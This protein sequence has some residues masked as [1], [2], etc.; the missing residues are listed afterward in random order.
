MAR[1]RS[2]N[3]NEYLTKVA[4]SQLGARGI[5]LDPTCAHTP[6]EN[7]AA[8]RI[9]RTLMNQV[10][11]TLTAARLPFAKYWPWCVLD[12]TGKINN[13]LHATTKQ[14]PVHVWE[15]CRSER[16]PFRPTTGRVDRF[17]VFGELGYVPIMREPKKKSDARATLARYL[18]TLGDTHYQVI[19]VHNGQL[20][21]VWRANFHPYK[22]E[23]DPVSTQRSVRLPIE[24]IQRRVNL[25]H[26]I[27]IT[28]LQAKVIAPQVRLVSN[29]RLP[30][31]VSDPPRTLRAARQS[32][33][34]T[35]WSMA[36][37]KELQTLA[38]FK[39]FRVT[40]RQN[41]PIGATIARPV[42]VFT[43][44]YDNVGA[45]KGHKAR[46]SYPGNI[47]EPGYHFDP[48]QLSVHAADRDSVRLVLA[49]AAELRWDIRHVDLTSAFLH[50]RYKGPRLFLEVPRSFDDVPP[51]RDTVLEVVGNMYG[52]QAAPKRYADGLKEH[53]LTHGYKQSPYDPHVYV[54]ETLHGV[55]IMA[56]TID[57]FAVT[58]SN[59]RLYREMVA[60]LRT[61]YQV[62]D[63]GS[64]SHLLGWCTKQDPHTKAVH[65]CQPHLAQAFVSTLSLHRAHPSL[66]P[67]CTMSLAPAKT[68]EAIVNVKLF[69]RALGMLRYLVDSTRPDLAVAT[70]ILSRHIQH[71]TRRHWAALRQVGRYIQGTI[72]HGLLYKNDAATKWPTSTEL[73]QKLRLRAQSD[74]AFADCSDSRRSTYG[75]L[76][77]LG[78]HLISWRT[79]TIKTVVTSTCSA[80]YIA[81]SNAARHATWLSSLLCELLQKERPPLSLAMDNTGAIAVA[82]KT[83]PT[84]RS[85]YI[86]VHYHVL[87]DL[88]ER[89][90]IAP[91]HVAS[92]QLEADIMTKPLR[93]EPFTRHRASLRIAPPWPHRP[94][95]VGGIIS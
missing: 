63:L 28:A 95:A 39:T 80:E 6:Q 89:K 87:R 71:P 33:E 27:P 90:L 53:L 82:R 49:L 46:V 10:R 19:I 84:K 61:K 44:K 16:S 15:Q 4:E 51:P 1:V 3:A 9:N 55:L 2:D 69:Q 18:F 93:L 76:V 72:N 22:V 5:R 68:D 42:T 77:M 50:E 62:K 67:Y 24:R 65:L 43:Y 91:H 48:A 57:D 78:P 94:E 12:T 40:R 37:N 60:A 56:V 29:T 79:A 38:A 66:T 21:R 26:A 81:A 14:I 75:F 85:K 35:K 20:L 64:P 92:R 7:G 25:H 8:E 11:A 86:D 47:L 74:A 17:R 31:P 30:S 83:S 59:H 70:C 36:Y 73:P 34:A 58:L 13:T 32:P 52:L 41:V 23:R 45:V 54:R 88:T